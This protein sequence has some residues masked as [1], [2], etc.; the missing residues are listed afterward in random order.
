M[1]GTSNL[2]I[3]NLSRFIQTVKLQLRHI[4][5]R[6]EKKEKMVTLDKQILQSS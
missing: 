4:F 1:W 2:K 3:S 6:E 5:D